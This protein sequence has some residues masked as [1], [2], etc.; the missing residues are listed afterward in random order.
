MDIFNYSGTKI[1][2]FLQVIEPVGQKRE[3]RP[4]YNIYNNQMCVLL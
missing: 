3:D 4:V 1:C 2:V